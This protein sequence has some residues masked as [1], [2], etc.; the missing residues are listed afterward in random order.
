MAPNPNSVNFYCNDCNKPTPHCSCVD[1]HK[2]RQRLVEEHTRLVVQNVSLQ[3]ELLLIELNLKMMNLILSQK[4]YSHQLR[5]ELLKNETK[6]QNLQSG[7]IEVLN[8][9]LDLMKTI[10]SKDLKQSAYFDLIDDFNAQI[11]DYKRDISELEAL[12]ER[13]ES[14][15]REIEQDYAETLIEWNLRRQLFQG[16]I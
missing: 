10:K 12:N 4:E 3:R 15:E 13:I 5:F 9:I 2:E 11:N 8:L 1:D 16:L 14:L 6:R 7:L